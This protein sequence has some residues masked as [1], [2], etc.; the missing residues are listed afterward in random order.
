[1][2][3]EARVCDVDNLGHNEKAS[4]LGNYDKIGNIIDL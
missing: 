4:F 2:Q 1:V 3:E